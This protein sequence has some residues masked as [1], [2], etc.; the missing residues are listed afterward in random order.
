MSSPLSNAVLLPNSTFS[1]GSPEASEI[2]GLTLWVFLICTLIFIFVAVWIW[3]S[4]IKFKDRGEAGE[5]NQDQIPKVYEITW[6]VIPTLICVLLGWMTVASMFGPKSGEPL[7]ITDPDIV[8]TG[9]QWWW[10]IRYPK[11]GVVTANE[12]H[13]PVGRPFVVEL[14]SNDVIHTFWIPDLGRKQQMIPGHHGF[15]TIQED[16]VGEFIGACAQ[17][18][19]NQHAWMRLLLVAQ[20]EE[21]FDAWAA[22]EKSSATA[23]AGTASGLGAAAEAPAVFTGN[24][25]SAN[26]SGNLASAPAPNDK[27]AQAAAASITIP[28]GRPSV[29]PTVAATEATPDALNS[30]PPSGNVPI[31][32]VSADG[33]VARG[34]ALFKLQTCASC[35]AIDGVSTARYA[36]DLSHIADRRT[37][38]AG[39]LVNNRENLFKWLHDPQAI[40]P[41]CNMP[42]F[43]LTDDQDNDLVS[44]LETLQ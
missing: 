22:K 6:T 1:T 17:Y 18:C 29:S 13:L 28:N 35:H 43:Q 37:L 36:P 23:L 21:D 44:Y 19:G 25:T 39:V 31:P 16:H 34:L 38:G 8:I 40:K 33:N 41:G 20:T 3:Y 30:L 11:L 10:E 5:P 14:E 15:I 42:N 7:R 26:T 32:N 24:A 4:V 2:T 12:L 9:A 27:A